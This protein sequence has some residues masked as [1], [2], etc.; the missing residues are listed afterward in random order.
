MDKVIN[1]KWDSD[2]FGLSIGS[3]NLKNNQ[4]VESIIENFKTYDVIYAF[5][6]TKLNLNPIYFESSKVYLRC[7]LEKIEFNF[8]NDNIYNIFEIEFDKENLISLA[9]QSGEFSRF[10]TDS[11]FGLVK[12]K[13]LYIKW[14]SKSFNSKENIITYISYDKYTKKI[15]GFITIE[16]FNKIG[17]FAVDN[18]FRGKGIGKNLLKKALETAKRNG[19]K[20][21]LVETQGNNVH[22]LEFYKRN[23]FE[24]YS[25]E[26]IYHLWN[27]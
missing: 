27:I 13:E 24:T 25:T 4:N 26:Y 8:L 21:I 3:I 17:L 6:D 10:K 7:L 2:F 18:K 14:I 22:A 19:Q 1:K 9:L 12:F 16:N 5:S 23:G 20:A 15:E 11:N